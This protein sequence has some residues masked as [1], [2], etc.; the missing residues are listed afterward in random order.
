MAW[1][2]SKDLCPSPLSHGIHPASGFLVG[3]APKIP[4]PGTH[5]HQASYEALR[6]VAGPQRKPATLIIIWVKRGERKGSPRAWVRPRR[7]RAHRTGA[8]SPGCR[9]AT[10][11]SPVSSA[12]TASRIL[13]GAAGGHAAASGAAD[14][15]PQRSLGTPQHAP[16]PTLAVNCGAACSCVVNTTDKT[17]GACLR[18][19]PKHETRRQVPRGPG[20]PHRGDGRAGV[21]GP[22]RPSGGGGGRAPTAQ[23]TTARLRLLMPATTPGAP[24][25]AGGK[26]GVWVV[27]GPGG[28]GGGIHPR[29]QAGFKPAQQSLGAAPRLQG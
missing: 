10:R 27:Q 22:T 28:P 25:G 29:P 14:A 3:S 8:S 20:P 9:A 15:L 12:P 19:K 4:P 7:P 26:G 6:M 17:V 21:A 1:V 2:R 13:T 11:P 18:A 23:A 16:P 5:P 24:P